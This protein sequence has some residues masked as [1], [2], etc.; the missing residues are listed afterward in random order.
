MR[1]KIKEQLF[2]LMSFACFLLMFISCIAVDY[3]FLFI[4]L[5]IAFGVATVATSRMWWNRWGQ[6]EDM[7]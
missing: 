5:S 6:Y 2:L 3:S 7:Q 4:V 1:D